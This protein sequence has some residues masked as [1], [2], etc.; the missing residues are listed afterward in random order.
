MAPRILL[1][2]GFS[3]GAGESHLHAIVRWLG[4][5]PENTRRQYLL[6][7]RARLAERRS[8]LENFSTYRNV[9]I[10]EYDAD[11]THTAVE[12]I[13]LARRRARTIS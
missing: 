1:Y 10:V 7:D 13:A 3:L 4:A 8:E 2:L 5:R 11:R 6:Q 12:R 9:T